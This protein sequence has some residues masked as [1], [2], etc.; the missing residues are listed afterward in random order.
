MF[1]PENFSP[2]PKDHDKVKARGREIC[3]KGLSVLD[4]GFGGREYIA[5]PFSIADAALFYV[6]YWAA[7]RMN[8]TLPPHCAAHFARMKGRAAVQRAMQQEGLAA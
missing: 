8:I 5:G 3:E 2:D 1:R 6:E 7:A 4:K